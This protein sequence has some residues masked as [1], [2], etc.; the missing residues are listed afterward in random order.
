MK[1]VSRIVQVLLRDIGEILASNL[2]LLP[3]LTQTNMVMFLIIVNAIRAMLTVIPA[4]DR[5]SFVL[6]A[7]LTIIYLDLFVTQH[8]LLQATQSLQQID[9]LYSIIQ[10]KI[11]IFL[12]IHY[13]PNQTYKKN[14]KKKRRYDKKCMNLKLI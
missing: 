13:L 11:I 5:L 6:L 9:V 3:V 10:F 2:V 8:V 4:Q 12:T 1:S 7:Q 14:S